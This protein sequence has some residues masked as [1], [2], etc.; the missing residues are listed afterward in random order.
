MIDK[1]RDF[2]KNGGNFIVICDSLG[3]VVQL[4]QTLFDV[5]WRYDTAYYDTSGKKNVIM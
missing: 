4:L 2:T 5:S 3:L 1:I